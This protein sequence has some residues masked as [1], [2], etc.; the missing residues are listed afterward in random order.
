MK[1]QISRIHLRSPAPFGRSAVVESHLGFDSRID[2]HSIK[3]SFD[4]DPRFVRVDVDGSD[5]F[6]LVPLTNCA[7]VRCKPVD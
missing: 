6:E 1:I 4:K 7:K 3:L 2:E 5:E